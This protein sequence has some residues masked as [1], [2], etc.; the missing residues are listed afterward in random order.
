M[1]NDTGYDVVVGPDENGRHVVVAVG[2]NYPG[3]V[4]I[5]AAKDDP[6]EPAADAQ[7]SAA[8]V[9]APPPAQGSTPTPPAAQPTTATPAPAASPEGNP[10]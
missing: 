8:P 2:E 5:E 4:A 1:R 6:P 10:S 3:T 7:P 9:P